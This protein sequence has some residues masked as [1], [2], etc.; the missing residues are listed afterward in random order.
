MDR[1]KFIMMCGL[2]GSGKFVKTQAQAEADAKMIAAQANADAM[3]IEADAEA[4]ANQKITSS[5]T[6]EILRKMYYDTWNGKL[7][8]V[9]AGTDNGM[10]IDVG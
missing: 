1:P 10:I 2:V 3:R 4:E 5:L 6:E 7:P 9:M 8:N